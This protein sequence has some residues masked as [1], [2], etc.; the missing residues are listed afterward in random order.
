M[1]EQTGFL[2][3]AGVNVA[4]ECRGGGGVACSSGAVGQT[5]VHCGPQ[6]L[7]GLPEVHLSKNV[8]LTL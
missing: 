3:D 7:A 5:L 1:P 2:G 4:S 6:C 8:M